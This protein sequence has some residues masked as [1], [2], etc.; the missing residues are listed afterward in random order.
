MDLVTILCGISVVIL[1]IYYYFT[2][3]FGF[4][5]SRGVRGPRPIP[6]FGTMKDV[7]L[8]K[9]SITEYMSE[10]Y[11]TYKDEPLIGIFSQRTPLLVVNDPDLIKDVLIKD[12]TTFADRGMNYDEKANPL[13]LHLFNLE[14]KR[15]RPLRTKLTPVFTSGKLKEM[16]HLISECADHLEKYT[17]I[18]TSQNKYVECREL[19]AKYTTD[20]IGS[21]AFGIEMNSLANEDAEFRKM[22]RSIF[23]PT[24]MNLIRFRLRDIVPKVYSFLT[25]IGILPRPEH[26]SFFMRVIR[27]TMDYR[28]KNNIVRHDFVDMLLEL[29][30]QGNLSD[31]S[32]HLLGRC[33]IF[34]HTRVCSRFGIYQTKIG[35]VKL[36]RNYK[37]ETCKETQIPYRINSK[38]VVLS[39]LG[40]IVLKITKIEKA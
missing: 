38:A 29:K 5:K 24:W 31:I 27:E 35:L 14:S 1:A 34:L 37:F 32:T 7:L 18:L 8:V 36:L 11:S 9:K 15:W 10:L 30:K 23:A 4:W 26:V 22:G 13:L 19:T 28:E 16:F 3:T 6:I 12:F 17:D 40:G 21:C 39:P 2:S 20:V 25:L 33:N